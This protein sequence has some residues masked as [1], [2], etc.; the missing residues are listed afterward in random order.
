MILPAKFHILLRPQYIG[1]A[2]V[3]AAIAIGY[4]I[5]VIRVNYRASEQFGQT[6]SSVFS[7]RIT[8]HDSTGK[9]LPNDLDEQ[10][11]PDY[12]SSAVP[13][14]KVDRTGKIQ[15]LFRLEGVVVF[16]QR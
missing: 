16:K 10:T 3:V 1:I 5:S 13:V 9:A 8:D 11:A 15:N 2:G 4:G 14:L 12:A 7:L 6:Q